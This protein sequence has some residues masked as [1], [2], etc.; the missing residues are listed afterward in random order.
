LQ[1]YGKGSVYDFVEHFEDNQIQYGVIR[2]PDGPQKTRDVFILWVGPSV[3][4]LDKGKKQAHIG[5]ITELLKPFHAELQA[6]S[7]KNFNLKTL[8]EKSHPFSG[9]HVID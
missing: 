4:I 6:I 8:M 3:P 5:E 2:L 1:Y 9:S 7:K